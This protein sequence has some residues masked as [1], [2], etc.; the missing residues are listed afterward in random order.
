MKPEEIKWN[1]WARIWAGEVP[2]EFYLELVIRAFFVYLLLMVSMRLMG[3][4]MSTQVSRLELAVIVALASAIGVPMLSVDRGLLPAVIIAAAVVGIH[5]L[6]AVISYKNERFERITQGSLTPLVEEGAM[7]YKKMETV[8]V[9]RERLFAQL[10]SENVHHLG[11][12]KR[13]YMEPNGTFALIKNDNPGPGLMMLPDSDVEFIS[14]HLKQ[15][16]T[17]ICKN[18]GARAPQEVKGV[19]SDAVCPN[20]KDHDWTFAV[21]SV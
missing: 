11:L 9:T 16:D 14:R 17:I 21:E 6:I 5:R 4:R 3:K 1:D 2:P 12:V 13:F 19:E 8:R 7:H 20:C 15:T 18:C 10:R